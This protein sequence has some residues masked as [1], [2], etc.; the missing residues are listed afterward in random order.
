MKISEKANKNHEELF[1]DH[2]STLKITD[3][4]LLKFLTIL[5]SMKYLVMEI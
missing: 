1:P 3:P 4:E 5:L 2:E